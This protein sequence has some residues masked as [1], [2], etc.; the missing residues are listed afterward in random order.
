MAFPIQFFLRN[1]IYGDISRVILNP[2]PGTAAPVPMP[3]NFADPVRDIGTAALVKSIVRWT[4]QAAEAL[5]LLTKRI[6]SA[7]NAGSVP[8]ALLEEVENAKKKWLDTA[9]NNPS[10]VNQ[11][12]KV[13]VNLLEGGKRIIYPLRLRGGDRVIKVKGRVAPGAE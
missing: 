2:A 13:H 1:N 12:K 10:I 3:Q 5:K 4:T 6:T 9:P 8:G 11:I 7:L